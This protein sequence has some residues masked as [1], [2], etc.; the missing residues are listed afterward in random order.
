M[1]NPIIDQLIAQITKTTDVED[2]AIA[3]INSITT[4]LIPN[5]VAAALKNGATEAELAP[6]TALIADLTAKDDALAAAVAANT[7]PP[8]P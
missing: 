5:A 8:T 6:F 1:A 2:S 4:T 3:L 7:V